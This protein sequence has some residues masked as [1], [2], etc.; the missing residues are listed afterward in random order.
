MAQ[1]RA[2]K[3]CRD[4]H[5]RNL[6]RVQPAEM[7]RIPLAAEERHRFVEWQADHVCIGANHFYDKRAREPLHR[8]AAGL[9]APLARGEIP[10]KVLAREPLEAHPRLDEA[11]A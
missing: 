4:V 11:L 9:A 8:V 6:D 3:P 10:F 7:D 2:M 5:A 1:A